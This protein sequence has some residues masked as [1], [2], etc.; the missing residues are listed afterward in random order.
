[1][2]VSGRSVTSLTDGSIGAI[3][4]IAGTSGNTSS[5]NLVTCGDGSGAGSSVIYT[6][7][8]LSSSGYNLTNITVYGGWAD[9]GR[10]QQA[11]TVYYSKVTAPTTFLLLGNVNYNP[12]NPANAQSATRATLTPASSVLATNVAAVKFD[13][14]TPASE[15]GYCGY[16]QIALFGAASISEPVTM[17]ATLLAGPGGFTMEAS[18]LATGQSYEIQSTT[19]L[20]STFWFTETNFVATQ[21]L[22]TFTNSTT[23]ASQKFYRLKA[24]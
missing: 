5:T 20:A 22:A 13:F 24:N 18:G 12:S 23:S 16:S 1:M 15:N 11:Y 7:T 8:N 21:G 3:R 9:A 6:L 10:D 4:L 17:R 14:S 19:N 2:E